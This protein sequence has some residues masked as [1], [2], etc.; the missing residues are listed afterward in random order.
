MFILFITKEMTLAS[1][2]SGVALVTMTQI[3]LI[4]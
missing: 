1:L 2:V 4:Q 3:I